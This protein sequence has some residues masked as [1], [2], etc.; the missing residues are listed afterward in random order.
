MFKRRTA[1][2]LRGFIKTLKK[3]PMAALAAKTR[4]EAFCGFLRK[5]P[6]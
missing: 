3:E 2:E 6:Q 1:A 4:H 5:G